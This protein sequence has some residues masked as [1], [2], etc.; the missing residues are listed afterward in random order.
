MGSKG[1]EVVVAARFS[2]CCFSEGRGLGVFLDEGLG[3]A[4]GAFVLMAELAQVGGLRRE[5]LVFGGFQGL[6]VGVTGGEFMNFA[7]EKRELVGTVGDGAVGKEGLLI[8]SEGGG[9]SA[10]EMFFAEELGKRFE[11]GHGGVL[12]RG[13]FFARGIFAKVAHC[14]FRR[15]GS[16]LFSLP[17]IGTHFLNIGGTGLKSSFF[18]W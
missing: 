9:G 6:A 4:G 2:P 10:V 7:G 16:V 14:S 15:A 11:S 18:G 3:N 8:P 13:W 5:V 17:C 1:G 12:E